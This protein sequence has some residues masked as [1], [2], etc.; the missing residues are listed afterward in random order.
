MSAEGVN[1]PP[2]HTEEILYISGNEVSE[3]E[4]KLQLNY[5]LNKG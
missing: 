2:V 3:F 1:I 4:E 5:K